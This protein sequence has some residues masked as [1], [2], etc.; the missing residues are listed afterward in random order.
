LGKTAFNG[1]PAGDA[2]H[3]LKILQLLILPRKGA[4]RIEATSKFEASI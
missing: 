4:K 2:T 1:Q 3:T